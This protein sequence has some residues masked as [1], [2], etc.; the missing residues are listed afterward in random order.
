MPFGIKS[1]VIFSFALIIL[2]MLIF[3]FK[4]K[5]PIRCFFMTALQGFGA[6]CAVNLVGIVSGIT[7]PL[8]LITLSTG[9]LAGIPGVILL[10]CLNIFLGK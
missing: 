7:L 10:L 6:I 4:S 9:G 1:I 5:H 8:N 2:T 3:A